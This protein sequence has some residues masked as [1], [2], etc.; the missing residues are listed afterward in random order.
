M[1]KGQVADSNYPSMHTLLVPHKYA[2]G[3]KLRFPRMDLK[4]HGWPK[5]DLIEY[6]SMAPRKLQYSTAQ[7]NTVHM[8]GG[9]L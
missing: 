1:S 5:R 3:K 9:C 2:E 4:C 8:D 6:L 7:Y